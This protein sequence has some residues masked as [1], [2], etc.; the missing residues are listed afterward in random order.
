[1]IYISSENADLTFDRAAYLANLAEKVENT[2]EWCVRLIKPWETVL[3][4]HWS[5]CETLSWADRLLR[6]VPLFEEM[7]LQYRLAI[8]WLNEQPDLKYRIV[9]LGD[10]TRV[11]V[12]APK[13]QFLSAAVSHF[14]ALLA[15]AHA[16]SANSPRFESGNRETQVNALVVEWKLCPRT[17][18]QRI[19]GQA[20]LEEKMPE[21][22][23]WVLDWL[24][25]NGYEFEFVPCGGFQGRPLN[26]GVFVNV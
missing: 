24:R 6:A 19:L 1:M 13:D 9:H 15:A 23:H 16:R 26:W 22:A 7:P 11:E 5:A 17:L 21:H 4:C 14:K 20:P 3:V 10:R 12:Q 25:G 2:R 8:E 18:K